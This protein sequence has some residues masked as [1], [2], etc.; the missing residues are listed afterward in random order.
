MPTKTQKPCSVIPKIGG[1]TVQTRGELAEAVTLASPNLIPTAPTTPAPT[2]TAK[3]PAD[4]PMDTSVHDASM[5]DLINRLINT[6][7]TDNTTSQGIP[8]IVFQISHY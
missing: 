7:M 3:A 1:L 5:E 6:T 8:D 2:M 4:I